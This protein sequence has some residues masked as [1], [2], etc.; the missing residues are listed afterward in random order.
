MFTLLGDTGA[1]PHKVNSSI[2]GKI[3]Y[4]LA[5]VITYKRWIRQ[6]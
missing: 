5:N 6:F 3:W 4:V 1:L 2:Y